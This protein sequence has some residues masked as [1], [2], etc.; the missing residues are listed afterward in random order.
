[1]GIV[2]SLPHDLKCSYLICA[3]SKPEFVIFEVC[4]VKQLLAHNI[5]V[6][7]F[8]IKISCDRLV[9]AYVP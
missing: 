7:F 5:G 8:V 4:G 3:V 2:A 1:M 6:T 9:K